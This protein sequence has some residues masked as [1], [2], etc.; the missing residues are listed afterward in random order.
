MF[1]ISLFC[2]ISTEIEAAYAVGRL[3]PILSGAVL[4]SKSENANCN[5]LTAWPP[6]WLAWRAGKA[7]AL[8]TV[9]HHSVEFHGLYASNFS[10]VSEHGCVVSIPFLGRNVQSSFSATD[11]RVDSTSILSMHNVI[12]VF[13]RMVS[14]PGLHWFGVS[15]NYRFTSLSSPPGPKSGQRSGILIQSLQH[16]GLRWR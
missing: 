15:S 16:E 14:T 2:V 10:F 9:W 4:V 13:R 7:S 5:S 8:P 12:I 6:R 1:W 3:P 11:G